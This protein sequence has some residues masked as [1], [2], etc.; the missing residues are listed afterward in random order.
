MTPFCKFY[1][2]VFKTKFHYNNTNQNCHHTYYLCYTNLKVHIFWFYFDYFG[3]VFHFTPLV[4]IKKLW[5]NKVYF[6]RGL[7]YAIFTDYKKRYD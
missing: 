7:F 4:T 2:A 3:F 5:Y 6:K 1:I